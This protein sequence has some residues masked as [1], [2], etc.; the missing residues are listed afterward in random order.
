MQI[1]V[2]VHYNVDIHMI[3]YIKWKSCEYIRM[4]VNI[5]LNIRTSTFCETLFK[6]YLQNQTLLYTHTIRW[7]CRDEMLVNNQNFV[8]IDKTQNFPS[9]HMVYIVIFW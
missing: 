8:T 4:Y 5:S 6:K 9:L 7:V 1:I 3:K 2:H